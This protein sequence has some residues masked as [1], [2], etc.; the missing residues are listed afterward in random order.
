VLSTR[1]FDLLS[2]PVDGAEAPVILTHTIHI[3]CIRCCPQTTQCPER[4]L[5]RKSGIDKGRSCEAKRPRGGEATDEP[6]RPLARKS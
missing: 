3:L 1:V 6:D 5:A 4:R 2:G